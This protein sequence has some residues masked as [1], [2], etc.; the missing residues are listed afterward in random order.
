MLNEE[1][2]VDVGQVTLTTRRYLSGRNGERQVAMLRVSAFR[3]RAGS[4][5]KSVAC[6]NLCLKDI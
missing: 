4:I 1:G 5:L 2:R 6:V 3:R